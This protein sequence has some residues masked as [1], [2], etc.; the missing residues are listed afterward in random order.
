M[1][2]LQKVCAMSH[3][4]RHTIRFRFDAK[5]QAPVISP[6]MA[7]LQLTNQCKRVLSLQSV[8]LGVRR[9][10][11]ASEHVFND[12][13][14]QQQQQQHEPIASRAKRHRDTAARPIATFLS[15]TCELKDRF[16]AQVHARYERLK[17]SPFV[18]RA[19]KRFVRTHP[20]LKHCGLAKSY[21]VQRFRPHYQQQQRRLPAFSYLKDRLLKKHC[22][23]ATAGRNSLLRS[24]QR[25]Q[26]LA[27]LLRPRMRR[28]QPKQRAHGLYQQLQALK[29]MAG[30]WRQRRGDCPRLP[31]AKRI[32]RRRR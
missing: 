3:G 1:R 31:L 2:R 20:E 4:N 23:Q 15:P 6:T 14:H 24:R 18:Q 30:A 21:P 22:P 11:S 25:R 5:Q 9:W 27:E 16:R 28:R 29:A 32:R 19:Y 13:S 12:N 8:R 26:P 10:T 7:L 17:R